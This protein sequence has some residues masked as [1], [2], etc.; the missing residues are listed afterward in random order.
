MDPNG[1]RSFAKSLS[2]CR[3]NTRF[4]HIVAGSSQAKTGRQQESK[5]AQTEPELWPQH[6][7][8]ITATVLVDSQALRIV[9]SYAELP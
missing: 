3:K 6:V 5:L 7:Q 1:T 4:E 8:G 9:Q 2:C